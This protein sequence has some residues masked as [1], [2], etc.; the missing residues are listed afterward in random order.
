[1][2]EVLPDQ[3]VRIDKIR[4]LGTKVGSKFAP[5]SPIVRSEPRRHRTQLRLR[6]ATCT[7]AHCVRID[8]IRS[9]RYQAGPEFGIRSP[10]R[11][12]RTP[13]LRRNRTRLRRRGVARTHPHRV[14]IEK[15]GQNPGIAQSQN[16]SASTRR[17]SHACALC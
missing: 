2:G 9:V 5:H 11:K 10:I 3:R 14:L 1:M 17:H 4:K 8:K 13:A 7:H 16:A 15:H 12:V 6:G